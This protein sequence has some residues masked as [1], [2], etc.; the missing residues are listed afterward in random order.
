[1]ASSK[2]WFA[3][4]AI[5][6]VSG[7][8]I[9]TPVATTNT[10]SGLFS[11]SGTWSSRVKN[12]RIEQGT[13]DVEPINVMGINQLLQENRPEIVTLTFNTVMYPQAAATDTTLFS[14]MFGTGTSL[15]GSGAGFIRYQGGEKAS[16]FRTNMAALVTMTRPGGAATDTMHILLNNAFTT[17]GPVTLDAEGHAEQEWTIK[18]LATDLYV[19]SGVTADPAT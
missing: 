15:S 8:V 16:G 19:D 5:V 2:V 18:C 7:T 14:F 17:A 1:M 9:S 6:A 4:D 3:K 13:M 10:V 12:V 11:A